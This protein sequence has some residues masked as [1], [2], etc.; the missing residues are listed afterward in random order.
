VNFGHGKLVE[1]EYTEKADLF[2]FAIILWEMITTR[3]PYSEHNEWR[4]AEAE[5]AIIG[6]V[7][8]QMP[9]KTPHP[10]PLIQLMVQC[11]SE[12]PSDRPSAMEVC[13]NIQQLLDKIRH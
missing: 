13:S 9:K 11:W 3:F 6:G 12:N 7:R 8:P 2:S 10:E 5:R 4:N 1:S